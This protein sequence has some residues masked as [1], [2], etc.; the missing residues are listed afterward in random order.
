MPNTVETL[1]LV[2]TEGA[3]LDVALREM[4][5]AGDAFAMFPFNTG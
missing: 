1:L 5:L 2:E 4:K 3:T